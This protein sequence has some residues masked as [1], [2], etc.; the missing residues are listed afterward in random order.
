MGV[1][2]EHGELVCGPP[3]P[4]GCFPVAPAPGF[5]SWSGPRGQVGR[6]RAG[7]PGLLGGPPGLGACG[8]PSSVRAGG[9]KWGD[10]DT[11]GGGKLTVRGSYGGAGR[12]GCRVKDGGCRCRRRGEQGDPLCG[13]IGCLPA[14]SLLLEGRVRWTLP[15]FRERRSSEFCPEQ[16]AGRGVMPT[17]G[18]S[19]DQGSDTRTEALGGRGPSGLRGPVSLRGLAPDPAWVPALGV[20]PAIP[21]S[22]RLPLLGCDILAGCGV[23]VRPRGRRPAGSGPALRE[24]RPA[25]GVTSPVAQAGGCGNWTTPLPLTQPEGLWVAA[26]G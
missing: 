4:E 24:R 21:V 13:H 17:A 12:G 22:S 26:R 19:Q 7:R 2:G 23:V 16:E 20:R 18:G 6:R 8:R 10:D 1:D 14:A 25:A 11:Q 5:L 15:G 3:R 9:R